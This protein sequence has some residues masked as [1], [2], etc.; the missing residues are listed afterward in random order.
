MLDQRR[1]VQ[2]Y[3]VLPRRA[4]KSLSVLM[5]MAL[6]DKT[7]KYPYDQHICIEIHDIRI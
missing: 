7:S 1:K 6:N 5:W 3:D 2:G 4:S